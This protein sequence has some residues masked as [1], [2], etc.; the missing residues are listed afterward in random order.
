MNTQLWPAEVRVGW[1]V[2]I[3]IIFAMAFA[4][5]VQAAE[6]TC[7]AGNVAC[8]TNAIITA[9]A[10]GQ[11]NTIHLAAGTYTLV[12]ADNSTDA[13]NG[14]PVI[15]SPLTIVGA[16]AASTILERADSAPFFRLLYVASGPF[17]L[18]G[19]T[20]R[21]GET[22]RPGAGLFNAGATVTIVSSTFDRNAAGFSF[23]GALFNGGGTVTITSSIFTNHTVESCGA[24]RSDE[25]VLVISD[26]TF[27][28]NASNFGPGVALNGGSLRITNSTFTG[29]SSGLFGGGIYFQ[30][31]VVSIADSTFANNSAVFGG[32][33]FNHSGGSFVSITNSTFADNSAQFGGGLYSVSGRVSITNSTFTGNSAESGGGLF[34]DTGNSRVS[35][36]NS[37]F[38]GNSAESGGGLFNSDSSVGGVELQNTILALNTASQSGPDCSGLTISLSNNLLGTTTGCT[39]ALQSADLTGEPGLGGFT[40]DG[41]PGNGHFPLL[42]ASRAINAGNDAA[43][44]PTDQL[45]EPRV[46]HCDIGAVEF[47]AAS[48]TIR[49]VVTISANLATLW[50]PNGKLVP[51]TVSG[52]ITDEADGSGVNASSAEYVVMD[53]YGQIQPRRAIALGADGR[54]AFTVALEASRRGNDKDGRHYTIAVSAK[55]R[56]GNLG[57]GSTIVTVPHDQ[58]K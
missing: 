5:G 44:S 41:T 1:L 46:G 55:D 22:S 25:G 35:I 24:I 49:P 39:I 27:A 32:G 42:S 53:E 52:T 54:Y 50:P 26:S 3:E 2:M 9:N 28:G 8:L 12:A 13:P 58:G 15:A 36:T 17:S 34:N 11:A 16:G 56:A 10:N 37:T 47:Q 57:V 19:L 30:I 29:N 20:L 7:P 45:D 21:G 14:L 43:C 40:D 23:G 4:S 48:D 6:F 51:V 38:A 18:V 33:L 31:A